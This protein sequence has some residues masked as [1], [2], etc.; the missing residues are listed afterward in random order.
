LVLNYLA[1]IA[2]RRGDAARAKAILSDALARDPQH[3]VLVHNAEVLRRS[4]AALEP[5]A[6]V[7]SHDFQLLERIVQPTLPGP[8][9][10]DVHV[11]SPPPAAPLRPVGSSAG[12]KLRV[13]TA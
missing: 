11:W 5:R 10:D 8:L 3:A 9:P 7:A 1:C 6:L 4:A 2:A 12:R 13:V